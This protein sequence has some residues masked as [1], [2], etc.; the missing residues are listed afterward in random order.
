MAPSSQSPSAAVAHH[1]GERRPRAHERSTAARAL[2]RLER[3]L[4]AAFGADYALLLDEHMRAAGVDGGLNGA[5]LRSLDGRPEDVAA[6]GDELAVRRAHERAR[7]GA[8]AASRRS[9]LPSTTLRA[10]EHGGKG[11]SSPALRA[12]DKFERMRLAAL[13][14]N[15]LVDAFEVMVLEG[16]DVA[17]AATAVLRDHATAEQLPRARAHLSDA[18]VIGE[19]MVGVPND[20]RPHWSELWGCEQGGIKIDPAAPNVTLTVSRYGRSPGGARA[21]WAQRLATSHHAD[22]R[23]WRSGGAAQ[24]EARMC[25]A[26]VHDRQPDAA[27]AD[28]GLI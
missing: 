24:R 22:A 27:F 12:P 14:P 8:R 17:S 13:D 2:K 16:A 6:L 10:I 5:L 23:A 4:E 18:S 26:G 9:K 28:A 20:G 15:A 7:A 11:A 19:R 1:G 21:G 25:I 3:N